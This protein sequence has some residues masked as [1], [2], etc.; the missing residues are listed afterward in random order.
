MTDPSME[1]P[2]DSSLAE[3]ADRIFESLAVRFPIC[4]ASD[5]FHFF[6]QAR[7]RA[8]D[9]TGWDDFSPASV[10]TAVAELMRW[11]DELD[12][13]RPALASTATLIDVEMLRRVVRTLREQLDLVRVHETQPTFYLTVVGIGIAEALDAGPQALDARLCRL[14]AFLDQAA[15]NLV[16]P[17][18][19][20]RDLGVDMLVKQRR[21]LASLPLAEDRR[22]PVDDAFG[23]LAAHLRQ[24]P[25]GD[26]FLPPVALYERIAADHIG[27]GLDADAIAREL[28]LEIEETRTILDRSA[29]AMAPGRSWQALVD[30]LACP[31]ETPGGQKRRYREIIAQLAGHCV[32]LGLV[33]ADA[34]A[35]CPVTVQ[36]IPD[37]MRPVRSNAAF[38]MP[39]VHP[40]TG[41]TF[42][43][44]ETGEALALPADYRLLTAHETY[45]GHHLL[46][47]CRWGHARPIRRHIEFPLFYE[48]WA[49]FAEELMFE[50]GFFSGPTDRLLMAK[51]RFWR[52]VRGKTDLDIHLRRKTPHE[53]T[54]YLT[55]QGLDS[56][57]AAA[58]V[59]RYIL[60]PGYQLAY[61]MGRRR[62]RGLYEECRQRGVQPVEFVRR[63]MAQGEIDFH[64]L[65]QLLQQGG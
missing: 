20:F 3:L 19:R 17:P 48:G 52:A 61:T 27:C 30:E 51:R 40:P 39:P 38:S 60:K 42:F 32:S 50:T 8:F 34:V 44:L 23:R 6:P 25:V 49:S 5:E 55:E 37:H 10:T 9:W 43:I 21:W 13:H 56:S 1:N 12:R 28:A 33:D 41:G 64:H 57:R 47:S 54:A 15:S 29:A 4:M 11:E 59:R 65:A 26:A 16:C 2:I 14:P 53:A 35:R 45:P 7:A 24:A 46:D 22:A 18:R 63:V 36:A 58:M 62:F 31:V